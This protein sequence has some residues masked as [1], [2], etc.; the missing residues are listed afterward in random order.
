MVKKVYHLRLFQSTPP[1][2]GATVYMY[3]YN[4]SSHVQSTPPEWGATMTGYSVIN[5]SGFNPRPRGGATL[6]VIVPING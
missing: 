1:E 6:T 2:W 5:F 3:K 4:P